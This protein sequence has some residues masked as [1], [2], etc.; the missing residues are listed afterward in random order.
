M[1]F[2][3]IIELLIFLVIL[4]VGY[5]IV[6]KLIMPA[7]PPPMQAI[8]WAIIGIIL[9]IALLGLGYQWHG[10]HGISVH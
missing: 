10:G 2:G 8:G 1:D 5:L 6:A 4:A 7:I 9:L 3:I